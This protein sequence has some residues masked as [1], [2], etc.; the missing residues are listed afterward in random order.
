M[1]VHIYLYIY[2]QVWNK[3]SGKANGHV[4]IGLHIPNRVNSEGVYLML[5]VNVEI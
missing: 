5:D 3:E 2:I 4:I 1:T